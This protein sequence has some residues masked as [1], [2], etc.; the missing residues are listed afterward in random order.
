MSSLL[1][2]DGDSDVDADELVNALISIDFAKT[3]NPFWPKEP[4][5]PQRCDVQAKVKR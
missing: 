4:K 3:L 5:Q 2:N 1:A